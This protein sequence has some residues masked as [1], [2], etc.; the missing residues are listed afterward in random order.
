MKEKQQHRNILFEKMSVELEC[1][2]QECDNGVGGAKY[3]TPSLE[4]DSALKMLDTHLADCHEVRGEGGRGAAAEGEEGGQLVRPSISRGCSQGEFE[5][6]K[7]AW[8]HYVKASN[9]END[10]ILRDQLFHCPDTELSLI[11]I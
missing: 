1:T 7:E 8:T 9:E 2:M 10:V 3:R 5:H 6:F 11:H 4:F